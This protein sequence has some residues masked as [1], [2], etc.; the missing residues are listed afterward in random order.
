MHHRLTRVRALL[1]AFVLFAAPMLACEFSL[2]SAA[3][4]NAVMAK[5]ARGENFD[6]VGVTDAYPFDQSKFHAIVTVS[7]APS[8]T[9]LKAVWTAVDVGSVAAPNTRIDQAEVKTQG[10]RNVDFTLAPDGD[11]WPPGTYKVD[12]YLN[13]KLDRSLNF[14][15]A[16]PPPTPTPSPRPPTS[17]PVPPT[18]T[19]SAPSTSPASQTCPPLPPAAV[20]P[21]GVISNVTMA[22]DAR[23]T[24]KDPVNPTTVFPPT[25]TFHAVV[26]TQNAPANTMFTA[27]WF[28]TDIGAPDCNVEIETA[29]LTTDGTRNIDF[30]LSPKTVWP[31][32]TYRVEI[33]VDDVLDQV[34][35]FTV[36]GSAPL[37]L[38][39]PT[40]ARP[41]APVATAT[42]PPSACG[43]IPAGKGAVI[44]KSNY[45]QEIL[46]DVPGKLV[47]IPPNGTSEPA[48]LPPGKQNY[49]AKINQVAEGNGTLDIQ[50]G[51]CLT[52]TFSP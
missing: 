44:F 14:T 35:S 51:G 1:F 28:A 52:F 20:H 8:D 46:V 15:V 43:S 13:D 34:V 40:P 45:G 21:S 29:E 16:A 2:S 27:T 4:T 49:H 42:R 9:A 23:G 26:A 19:P 39:T 22:L 31:N 50:E 30:T 10:S 37:N 18:R 11:R 32:G 7:N 36:G 25:A 38:A 17:T 6:P 12:I 33:S 24:T 47:R 41:P 48:Y 5:D 3:I